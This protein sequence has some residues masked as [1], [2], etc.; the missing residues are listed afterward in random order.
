MAWPKGTPR[1]EGAGRKKGTPNKNTGLLKE[2][3]L[4]ALDEQDGGGIAYLKRQ[5]EN[6]PTAFMTLLGKVLPTQVTGDP[7]NPVRLEFGWL[8]PNK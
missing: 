6:N 8:E 2:M 1:P 7:E 5:A 3:I 4:Q